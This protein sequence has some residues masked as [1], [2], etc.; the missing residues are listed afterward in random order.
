[1][2]T[3][4]STLN[5]ASDEPGSD[6]SRALAV[7]SPQYLQLTNK[8]GTESEYVRDGWSWGGFS[9]GVFWLVRHRVWSSIILSVLA[10]IG[11]GVALL[12]SVKYLGNTEF[13]KSIAALTIAALLLIHLFLGKRG[14]FWR[15][16]ALVERGWIPVRKIFAK[17][18]DEAMEVGE[19]ALADLPVHQ[20]PTMGLGAGSNESAGKPELP[21]LRPLLKTGEPEIRTVRRP[22]STTGSNSLD[23]KTASQNTKTPPAASSNDTGDAATLSAKAQADAKVDSTWK[24][25]SQKI[26]QTRSDGGASDTDSSSAAV[27]SK[28]ESVVSDTSRFDAPSPLLNRANSASTKDK[29]EAAKSASASMSASMTTDTAPATPTSQATATPT[30]DS[31]DSKKAADNNL[32]VDPTVA[33]ADD[34]ASEPETEVRRKD[35][36]L[37]QDPSQIDDDGKETPVRKRPTFSGSPEAMFERTLG[38]PRKR[39][40]ATG[41]NETSDETTEPR[42]RATPDASRLSA[43]NSTSTRAT[44]SGSPRRPAP[45]SGPESTERERVRVEPTLRP[46]T[47]PKPAVPAA[48]A[49]SSAAK[50]SS[51]DAESR[52]KLENENNELFEVAWNEIESD[53]M[54]S[55]LEARALTQHPD[56]TDQRKALYIRMRVAQLREERLLAREEAAAARRRRAQRIAELEREEIYRDF[57]QIVKPDHAALRGAKP[58]LANFARSTD[59]DSDLSLKVLNDAVESIGMT[60]VFAPMAGYVAECADGQMLE[61]GNRE[62]L[63]EFLLVLM[64]SDRTV[65]N[66]AANREGSTTGLPGSP[67]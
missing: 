11:G 28:D 58:T 21:E 5:P 6:S 38:G 23:S 33:G 18:V 37:G 4:S 51:A 42:V 62:Q 47:V 31:I 32:R 25:A 63:N 43:N 34:S 9:F 40:A 13:V 61:L 52:R 67:S 53:N 15:Q 27:N 10:L 57:V 55:A 56:N 50:Q 12:A 19:S 35:R 16:S 17:N 22:E 8:S 44:T 26:A 48:P 54:I 46:Q 49:P 60:V 2:A 30:T 64:N 7:K 41:A 29:A 3:D 39:S 45:E 36:R 20:V 1:M 66:S 59:A 14:N 65:S 24:V